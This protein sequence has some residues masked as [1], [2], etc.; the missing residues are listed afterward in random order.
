M[1]VTEEMVI[2]NTKWLSEEFKLSPQKVAR[3]LKSLGATRIAKGN[4]HVGSK[5]TWIEQTS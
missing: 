2:W 3:V 4:G 1:A 5:W